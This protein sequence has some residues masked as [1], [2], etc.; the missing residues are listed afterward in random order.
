MRE[1]AGREHPAEGVYIFRGQATIVFATVCSHKRQLQLATSEVH[2]ALIRA[3]READAWIIGSYLIMPDH[4]HLFCSPKNEDYT[5][6][7]WITFWKRRAC[8][9]LNR[10]GEFFRHMV[11]TIGSDTMRVTR[12]SG[13]TCG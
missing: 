12:K 10:A 9:H 13:I 5:I 2:D 7:R 6:E 11:F 1:H 4:I 8:R 3:W